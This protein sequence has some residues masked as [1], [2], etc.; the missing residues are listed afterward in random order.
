MTGVAGAVDAPTTT[1]QPP[2]AVGSVVWARPRPPQYRYQGMHY[3]GCWPGVLRGIRPQNASQP[4]ANWWCDVSPCGSPEGRTV[5]LATDKGEISDRP[6]SECLGLFA[7]WQFQGL[8]R[9][10][11]TSAAAGVT[12]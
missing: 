2:Y 4:D 11:D 12:V 7:A 10:A 8:L 9:E 6:C 3:S 1:T 5:L